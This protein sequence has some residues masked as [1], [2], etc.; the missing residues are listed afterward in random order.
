MPSKQAPVFRCNEIPNFSGLRVRIN[1]TLLVTLPSLT[2][3]FVDP[4]MTM[5]AVHTI[6]DRVEQSLGELMSG[7]DVVVH[8][9]PL[10]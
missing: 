10:K 7:G 2:S 5:E 4:T 9:E 6:A 1:S 8:T 3:S